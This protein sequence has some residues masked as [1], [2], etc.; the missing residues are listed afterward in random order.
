VNR[1]SL[2]LPLAASLASLPCFSDTGPEYLENETEQDP[3]SSGFILFQ[4]PF[5]EKRDNLLHLRTFYQDRTL[6]GAPDREDWAGGGWVSAVGSYWQSR[7]KVAGT[8]YTSQKL[9]ADDDKANTGALQKG[10]NSYS[11]L[12]E[13]YASLTLDDLAVQAGRYAINLPYINKHDIRMTPQ[14]FQGAQGIYRFSDAWSFGGGVVTQ[15][16][17]RTREGF[18]SMYKRAGLEDDENVYIAGSVYQSEPGSLA[19]IYG[20]HAPDFHN[21]IYIELSKRFWL[22]KN[23]YIQLSGQYT[24]QESTGDELDGEFTVNHFGGRLTWKD[25]WYSGSLAYT[26]YPE[27]DRLRRPWGAIPGYTSVMISDFDRPEESAWLLGGT[28][29]LDSLGAPGLS[30][31]AKAIAGDTPDCGGT[32][33]PDQQEYN[34]NFK[35]RPGMA[36]L[37]GLLLQLRFARVYRD[38]TCRGNDGVDVSEVRFV[39]NY[40]MDF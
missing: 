24:R 39:V 21:G 29:D 16:K 34:L 13:V 18:D 20:L 37:A 32:A 31:N 35:Y 19:G 2:W 7:L 8:A 12:G 30:I 36:K 1:G 33:S 5:E 9:Y 10:H 11:V 26:D 3:L 28:V 6:D 23:R 15:L 17:G 22:N 14:T 40:E 27:K 4:L 38:D 25:G